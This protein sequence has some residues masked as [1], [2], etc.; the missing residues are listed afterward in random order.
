MRW[1]SILALFSE[2][3]NFSALTLYLGLVGV[4]LALLISLLDFL[5]LELVANEGACA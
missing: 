2:A 1:G 5:S 4:H 3:L